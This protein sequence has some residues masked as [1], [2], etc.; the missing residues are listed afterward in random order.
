M[1]LAAFSADGRWLVTV[2]TDGLRVWD[3]TTGEPISPLLKR[4]PEQP[5]PHGV[6]LGRDG[7]LVLAVGIPGDPLGLETRQ[8]RADDRPVGDLLLIAEIVGGQRLADAGETAAF[9][10]AELGKAWQVVQQKYSKEFTPAAGRAAAWDQRGAAECEHRQLWTGAVQ[11]LTRLIAQC[12]SADLYARRALAHSELGNGE[13]ARADYSKA[14]EGN[15][16]RWDLWAGRAGVD[17]GLGRWEQ[18]AADYSKA[19]ERKSD[20]A[21]LWIGRARAEAERGDW[22]KSAADFA[23]AIHLGNGEASIWRQHALALLASGDEANYRRW[24]E[25]LVQR[26]GGSND[27]AMARSVAWTCALTSG[28]VRDLKPLMQRAERAVKANPQSADDLRRLAL[29]LYRAGQFHAALTR[30][31]EINQLSETKAEARDFMLMALTQQRLGRGEEAKKW[32]DKAEKVS[33]EKAKGMANPWDERLAYQML[34]REAQTLVKGTK[35]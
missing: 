35:R 24:C 11:H 10:G 33:Q 19:I 1:T 13:A 34:H 27:E 32:L 21:E 3:A 23:K 16:E 9:D 12:A 30:L 18:A 17:A 5:I 20:R 31:Q 26:F 6:R 22:T 25:R 4:G 29:L 7:R 14:L 15:A 8:L 28:G 2:A